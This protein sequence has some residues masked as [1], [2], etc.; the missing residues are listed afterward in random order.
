MIFTTKSQNLISLQNILTT[1]KILPQFCFTAEQWKNESND[2]LN[3]FFTLYKWSDKKLIVRSSAVCEDSAFQSYAGYYDSILNV[4][5]VKKLESAIESVYQS[6]ENYNP[7][8]EIFIQPMLENVDIS[9]V[10]FTKDPSNNTPYYVLNYSLSSSTDAITAGTS[11]ENVSYISKQF[12]GLDKDSWQFKLCSLCKELEKI[13]GLD[14]LDIE[15]AVDKNK[16]L[17]LFQV[18]PLIIKSLDNFCDQEHFK[19]LK[20]LEA[21][22]SRFIKPH[23]YLNGERSVLGIMPDWNPAEIIGVRPRPLALSLYKEL[24]TDSTWAYQRNNYGYKQLRSFPLL[25]SLAG[26][27]YIDVRVSFNSFI[28]KD[29]PDR[30]AEKLVN[31]Y[32][33]EL[34]NAPEKHDKVEFDIIFS[35]FTLDL[36]E[37]L[38]RLSEA[39][40]S[41]SELITFTES[42]KKLTNNIIK[43]DGLW[44][45]DIEKINTLPNRRIKI[46]SSDLSKVEKIHWLLEDCKRYGTLPFAGLARAGFIAVQFLRSMVAKNII[47]EQDY[48]KFLSSIATVSSTLKQDFINLPLSSFLQQYGHLRP[49]TYDILSPRYDKAPERYFNQSDKNVE[50][51]TFDNFTLSLEQLSA[52]KELLEKSGIEHDV[53]SLFSFIKGAIEG[54]EYA[55]FI[56]T[57][58]LSDALELIT[59]LGLEHQL[60]TDDMSYVDISSILKTYS[61]SDDLLNIIKSSIDTGKKNHLKA[62]QITLPPLISSPSDAYF[63]NMPEGEPNYITQGK[64]VAETTMNPAAHEELAG[65]IVF[66]PS[67]DPGF[68]WLFSHPIAGLI[69]KYGGCNSHM[70][71]R[72]GELNI[73][74]VIGAGE[75]LYAKWLKA[76]KLELDANNKKVIIIR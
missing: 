54:R 6:F 9:G 3:S 60:N 62:Q 45:K 43:N 76:E 56:F 30:L 50:E 49:G 28:P 58:S 24:I 20:T 41:E 66:I 48:N 7:N 37:R 64:I 70:A 27:P 57:H 8:D 40:F 18:R 36:N 32:I 39:G 19:I 29:T 11:N 52:L 73:P 21:T 44:K 13:Y 38:K 53:I 25:L 67:A 17:Y 4:V 1:A 5:G 2:V 22:I 33:N 74:S 65:K 47:T 63:F 61:S 23:P 12:D 69:T 75:I 35:C 51:Q 15:F 31:Y 16:H 55:K 42:L 72:A 68:D 14:A 26:L 46:L 59:E 71:I 10:A 34:K